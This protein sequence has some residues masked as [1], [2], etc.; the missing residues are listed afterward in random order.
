V[1][2]LF[3]K[4]LGVIV[5]HHVQQFFGVILLSKR[6]LS[7]SRLWRYKWREAV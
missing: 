6:S 4:V 5:I 3:E 1:A 7:A 2:R